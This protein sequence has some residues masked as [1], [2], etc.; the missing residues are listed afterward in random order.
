MG[1]L[2][3]PI[4]FI[5]IVQTLYEISFM[6]TTSVWANEQTDG[7]MNVPTGLPKTFADTFEGIIKMRKVVLLWR[8]LIVYQGS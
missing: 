5:D 1:L 2:I 6:V 3:I 8:T 4:S 7:R